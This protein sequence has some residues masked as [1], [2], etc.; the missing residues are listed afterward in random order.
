MLEKIK[1]NELAKNLNISSKN[2]IEALAKFDIQI[3]SHATVL[4]ERQLDMIF[5]VRTKEGTKLVQN[6][7]QIA[8][9]KCAE[10]LSHDGERRF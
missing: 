1:V 10:L 9:V 4:E 3:K 2:I 7:M 8:G 6:C 5:E